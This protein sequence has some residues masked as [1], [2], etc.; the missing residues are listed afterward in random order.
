MKGRCEIFILRLKRFF[1]RF[2]SHFSWSCYDVKT[3]KNSSV[4]EAIAHALNDA[5]WTTPWAMTNFRTAKQ[6]VSM[7]LNDWSYAKKRNYEKVGSFFFHIQAGFFQKFQ[8]WCENVNFPPNL[9]TTSFSFFSWRFSRFPPLNALF[10]VHVTFDR[11]ERRH[12]RVDWRRFHIAHIVI[13]R[14]NHD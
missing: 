12:G 8:E 4:S 14:R 11:T 5:I 3:K 9:K 10:G 13:F 6:R 1:W 7:I 2:S